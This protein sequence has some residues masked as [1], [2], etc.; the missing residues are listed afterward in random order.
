MEK[1]TQST[2]VPPSVVYQIIDVELY[3]IGVFDDLE[4]AKA[5]ATKLHKR[6]DEF[7]QINEIPL[8][9]IGNYG[10]CFKCIW[11]VGNLPLF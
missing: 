1:D 10:A 11:T 2:A 7:Y 5:A 6:H 4:A 9:S 3:T 8:N